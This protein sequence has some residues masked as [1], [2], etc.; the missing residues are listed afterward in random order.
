MNEKGI[1]NKIVSKRTKLSEAER[2]EILE[3]ISKTSVDYAN[4]ETKRDSQPNSISSVSSDKTNPLSNKVYDGVS[5]HELAKLCKKEIG[6]KGG[7]VFS[8]TD[9]NPYENQEKKEF[10][11]VQR[12]IIKIAEDGVVV[13]NNENNSVS[14][15]STIPL[16]ITP[17]NDGKRGSAS[18]IIS[19]TS[20]TA[21][22]DENEYR[23]SSIT[24]TLMNNSMK[25]LLLSMGATTNDI[26]EYKENFNGSESSNENNE[27]EN[28]NGSAV[29]SCIINTGNNANN[30]PDYLEYQEIDEEKLELARK[31]RMGEIILSR[32]EIDDLVVLGALD[33][34]VNSEDISIA[35]EFH[36]KN[37]SA[38]SYIQ[39]NVNQ[40]NSEEFKD[41]NAKVSKAHKK[42]QKIES[43]NNNSNNDSLS[44]KSAD[45]ADNLEALKALYKS[46][47][48]S[49]EQKKEK[50]PW[51][52]ND[53]KRNA[54]VYN[55]MEKKEHKTK[56]MAIKNE[57]RTGVSFVLKPIL[58]Q[59]KHNNKNIGNPK[60]K[61][62][63]SEISIFS[64]NSNYSFN[65]QEADKFQKEELEKSSNK[66]GSNESEWVVANVIETILNSALGETE[67]KKQ[68]SNVLEEIELNQV[69]QI[70]NQL[71]SK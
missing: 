30:T 15:V 69:N 66:F 8:D 14:T 17:P 47:N 16:P 61:K 46:K 3:E 20:T 29:G 27:A 49:L 2:L 41:Y 55:R 12:D 64:F 25:D 1:K 5:V 70:S 4:N 9:S 54:Y 52:K 7:S 48:E 37:K 65:T 68:F 32:Q 71:D 13:N 33:A 28:E 43:L 19:T 31:Y 10:I 42:L 39:E 6:Y 59:S 23:R 36:K 35:K 11:F 38:F 53:N 21:I 51:L 40:Q 44:Q 18:S 57:H 63:G 45:K 50:N 24:E 60:V 22:I 58:F 26:Q 67:G 62:R 34:S 56:D